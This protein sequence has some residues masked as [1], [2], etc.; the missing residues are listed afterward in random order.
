MAIALVEGNPVVFKPAE[1]TPWCAQ[2]IAEM[3]DDAG[4]PDGVFNMVQGFGDAG[5]HRRA[6]R[7]Q[8]RPFHRFRRGRPSHPRQ[9]R[10]R[11]RQARRL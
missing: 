7:R 5:R 4:I 2:I 1:Q 9:A 11:R 6:R 8:D 3:F 10:R